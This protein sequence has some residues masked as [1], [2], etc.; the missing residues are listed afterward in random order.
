VADLF[1]SYSR[2]DEPF[3]ERLREALGKR[4]RDVWLDREDIGPAVEWRREIELGIE[5]ADVF[6]F[7]IS[8]DA[9]RSEP[10]RREREY[11]VTKNKRIVPLLRRE[12]EEIS[13]PEDLASRNYI[14]FRTDEEF[15][16]GV[17]SLLAAIEDLPEWA[18]D[19]TRLLQRAE[20]WERSDRDP[21]FLLRGS[22]LTE[23][24]RWLSEQAA[25]KEPQPTPL[26]T[27][28]LLASRKAATR[29]QRITIGAVGLALAVSV[30]LGLV[31]VLQRNEAVRQAQLA[32]SRELAATSDAAVR[33]DP[34]EALELA[35]EAAETS[36]TPEAT[37]ALRG[38]LEAPR[39]SAVLELPGSPIKT[40]WFI[41]S[42]HVLTTTIAGRLQRWNLA[43]EDY[44]SAGRQT[45]FGRTPPSSELSP[46][47]GLRIT[48]AIKGVRVSDARSGTRLIELDRLGGG[49]E[50]AIRGAHFSPDGR[51]FLTVGYDGRVQIWPL[52]FTLLGAREAAAGAIT[53]DGGRCLTADLE[54]TVAVWS[55]AS[56]EKLWSRRLPA[57]DVP[58]NLRT[59][60]ADF[61]ADG[62][63]VVVST[64]L[65]TTVV[66][67]ESGQ[68]LSQLPGSPGQE[69]SQLRG[70]PD[71]MVSPTISPSGLLAVR[72][73][74]DDRAKVIGLPEEN[75]IRTLPVDLG[76][77]RRVVFSDNDRRVVT[78]F[79]QDPVVRVWGL[80][81]DPQVAI[82][83]FEGPVEDVDLSA[84]GSILLTASGTNASAS[85]LERWDAASGERVG[86]LTTP[87]YVFTAA[88]AADERFVVTGGVVTAE[89]DGTARVWE[90][91]TGRPVAAYP[92]DRESPVEASLSADGRLLAVRAHGAAL[93]FDCPACH[94]ASELLDL[95]RAELERRPASVAPPAGP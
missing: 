64:G 67:A 72:A 94:P 8:P 39:E 27:E 28:Y 87:D 83:R 29:R 49:V 60:H 91:S 34:W 38:A 13:V 78:S 32:K 45:T 40:A 57:P 50:G 33:T 37:D 22:D 90:T 75:Q 47:G 61:S 59:V 84:D 66:D 52:G 12:P 31:A 11:A 93:V 3:V 26:Q 95:A 89:S 14:F 92:V 88:F 21:S 36:T 79:R 19:H 9:L 17:V 76:F 82:Q 63:Q 77:G 44:V 6:A 42:A 20:Q 55:C 65:S 51:S 54:V 4:D 25:H 16:P 43:T 1:L 41:D 80:P 85:T 81:S 56:G 35:T 68:D 30:I 5:G 24:E 15:D 7:V 18:R 74:A 23:A 69:L 10:C 53:E 48:A 73:L 46:D 70:S 71:L 86:A 2:R 62:A 58:N